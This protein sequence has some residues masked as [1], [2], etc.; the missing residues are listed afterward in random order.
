M[1]VNVDMPEI[2]SPAMTVHPAPVNKKS[3]EKTHPSDKL[4]APKD[5]ESLKPES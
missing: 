4:E 2:G 1:K 3:D 5:D